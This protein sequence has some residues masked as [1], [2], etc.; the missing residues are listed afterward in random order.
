MHGGNKYVPYQSAPSLTLQVGPLLKGG[1]ISA[2]FL[3]EWGGRVG[4]GKGQ[5][6][7]SPF[8]GLRQLW[9]FSLEK[10]SGKT[11]CFPI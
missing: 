5:T 11:S 2:Q 10:S 8:A 4:E 3:Q 7:L 6:L 9:D 1:H